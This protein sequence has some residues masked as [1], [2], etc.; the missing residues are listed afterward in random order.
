MMYIIEIKRYKV[1]QELIGGFLEPTVLSRS[2]NLWGGEQSK[3]TGR[4]SCGRSSFAVAYLITSNYFSLLLVFTH[5]ISYVPSPS[6]N[7]LPFHH[8]VLSYSH[9]QIF[10][11]LIAPFLLRF[12]AGSPSLLLDL[13]S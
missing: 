5:P 13:I 7:L 9:L 2:S 4:H 1:L 6:P 10:S 3:P 11:S 12:H 8:L